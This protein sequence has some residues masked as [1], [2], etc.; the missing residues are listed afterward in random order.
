MLD[1]LVA[2]EHI[3]FPAASGSASGSGA[4]P[5][6]PVV[7]I[8]IDTRPS[9][10][11]LAAAVTAGAAA[12]GAT[13]RDSGL[14][15]TPQLHH[16]VRVNNAPLSIPD[17]IRATTTPSYAGEEGYYAMLRDGFVGVLDGEE[18]ADASLLSSRG[19]VIVDC[20][21]GVGAPKAAALA[22]HFA[23]LVDFRLRNTGSTPE[24]AAR[25]NDGVG[26]EHAQ[27]ERLPPAGFAHPA[28]AGLRCA[29]LDGDAD[30]LVYHYFGANGTWN[31]IDGDKIACLAASFIARLLADAGLA[32][33][34]EATHAEH[35]SSEAHAHGSGSGSGSSAAA[36]GGSLRSAPVSVGIVQTAYAN[37]ASTYYVKDTLH[38]PVV[39]AKTGVKYVHAVA[40]RYDVGVYFEAN[41]HGTVLFH[42]QFVA[43]LAAALAAPRADVEKEYGAAGARALRRLFWSTFLVNQAIGDA[44]SDLLFAEA[45]LAL[46]K[47][48]VAA[49]DAV[50][51]DLPSRQK[52][53][54]VPDRLAVRVNADETRVLQPEALQSRIDALVASTPKGRAFLRPSGTE[55]VVRVYAEAETQEAANVL[56]DG[57]VAAAAE[58]LGKA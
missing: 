14:V 20:A 54:A 15:T 8:G 26:A 13:V 21:H 35:G 51:T 46:S 39:C 33:T 32:V 19:P 28:D 3:S 42:H 6:A 58:I 17:G 36:S 56:A 41:G 9:S 37:G 50:Y 31:L 53:L 48:D 25:L 47:W 16:I 18:A 11:R 45:V 43:K 40:T 10:A 52:K 2:A 12:L 24:E 49:W 7:F 4:S 23:S 34:G 57:V 44:L 29:S 22:S 5:S 1:A 55:D 38:L 27:K 30:R